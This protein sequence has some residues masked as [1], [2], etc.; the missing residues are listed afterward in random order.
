MK[1]NLF[2]QL[3]PQQMDYFALLSIQKLN[4]TI[5][6]S[7]PHKTF[8]ANWN[9]AQQDEKPHK[10]FV[11]YEYIYKWSLNSDTFLEYEIYIVHL[12]PEFIE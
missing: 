1:S 8:A 6:N 7:I 4:L 9:S 10:K 12:M 3:I 11:S 5:Q 2:S